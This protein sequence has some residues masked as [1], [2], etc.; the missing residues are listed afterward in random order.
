VSTRA[1]I[2]LERV[3]ESLADSATLDWPALERAHPKLAGTLARLRALERLAMAHRSAGEALGPATE[4]VGKL[5]ASRPATEPTAR[6]TET[7]FRWGSLIVHERLGEG[8]FGEV[9]RA[10]DPALGRDVALKLRRVSEG[11]PAH[12]AR[13]PTRAWLAE[14]RRLARLSHPNVLAVLGVGEHNGR[15]GLWT[16]LVRGETLEAR[17]VREGP[18]SPREV[19]LVGVDLCRALAAVHAER[20][21]HGDVK[22]ANVMCERGSA[23]KRP[24]RI[25]LMDFGAGQ[26]G[27]PG[28]PATWTPLVSAPELLQGG[29]VSVA[30]DQYALGVLLYRLLTA[31]WPFEA[32]N[33]AE[34]VE[35]TARTSPP[36]RELRPDLPPVLHDAVLRSLAR[37]PDA[38]H[39]NLSAFERALAA[40]VDAVEPRLASGRR[41]P[42]LLAVAVLGAVLLV[43]LWLSVLELRAPR[44]QLAGAVGSAPAPAPAGQLE[45]SATLIRRTAGGSEP[46]VDGG[47]VRAGDRLALELRAPEPVWIYVLDEDAAGGAY[48]LFPLD[49]L[50][51][52]NPLVAGVNHRLPGA[53]RGRDLA[54]QV[55]ERG[56]TETFLVVASRS[57]RPEIDAVERGLT[58]AAQASPAA[59]GPRS[60]PGGGPS[61]RAGASRVERGVEGLVEE[62][63]APAGPHAGPGPVTRLAERLASMH[64]PNLWLWRITARHGPPEPG[65]P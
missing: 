48:A 25:V 39:A 50:E 21:V 5:A 65:R 52:R 59:R 8:T 36:L 17:L 33:V 11:V 54:W 7:A 27:P 62:T 26:E 28:S 60:S 10:H 44:A 46:L 15:A 55:G 63:Q 18:L 29:Q 42:F 41:V 37:S 14:A 32:E 34:L 53:L 43:S 51:Q 22:T 16:E 31:R 3:A 58:A 6:P 30:T 20:L 38:R 56:G 19:A 4:A 49:D 61:D 2:D 45:V 64:D 1:P 47:V 35:A 23:A 9:Y 12:W 24:G 40:S 13:R 57:A